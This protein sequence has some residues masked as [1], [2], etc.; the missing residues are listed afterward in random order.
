MVRTRRAWLSL[1]L[2]GVVAVILVVAP[3]AVEAQAVRIPRIGILS[4]TTADNPLMKAFEQ[5]L[6]QQGYVTNKTVR[7]ETRHTDGRGDRLLD[8]AKELAD[9]KVDVIAVW[10]SAGALAAQQATRTIPIVFVSVTTP[11]KIGL[12]QSVARPGGNIT[13]VAFT[14]TN[15]TYSKTLA[16]LKEAV[17]T[18][19]RVAIL[20]GQA[21]PLTMQ[22]IESAVRDLKITAE[23]H[24]ATEPERLDDALAAIRRSAVDAMYV[25]PSGLAYQHRKKIVAFSAS[26]RL[27]TVYPFREAVDDGG[28]LSFGASQV[29]MA[30]QAAS[31]IVRILK[32]ARPGDLPVEQPTTYELFINLKAAKTLNLALPRPLLLRADEIIE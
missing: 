24:T 25:P 16:I 1:R 2:A 32:G 27:P 23:P 28:L 31:F 26:S 19:T 7:F 15:A 9:A 5:S 4:P 29:G 8:F 21:N 22:A 11:E 10:S 18:A 6:A 12:V 13:G 17:P 20:L 3:L 30:R 14:A